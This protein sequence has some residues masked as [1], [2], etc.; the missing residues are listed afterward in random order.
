VF[1][2][3]C[4]S[5]YEGPYCAIKTPEHS[6]AEVALLASLGTLL[7]VAAILVIAIAIAYIIKKNRQQ[8]LQRTTN[9]SKLVS[10]FVNICSSWELVRLA[11]YKFV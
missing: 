8:Q 7:P 11:R 1:C 6:Q 10:L 4:Q 9:I 5:G 3:S 2:C